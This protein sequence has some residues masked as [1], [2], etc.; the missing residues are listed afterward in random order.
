MKAVTLLARW[1]VAASSAQAVATPRVGHSCIGC[2][3]NRAC[4]VDAAAFGDDDVE[5]VGRRYFSDRG[6]DRFPLRGSS[7]RRG[8]VAPS[9]P[10]NLAA[11]RRIGQEIGVEASI[12][13]TVPDFSQLLPCRIAKGVVTVAVH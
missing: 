2:R 12:G 8:S 9:H 5:A 6:T 1:A 10:T 7:E 11:H 4:V 13:R 3:V